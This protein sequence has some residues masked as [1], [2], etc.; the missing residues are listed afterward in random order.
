MLARMFAWVG[1]SLVW[2]LGLVRFLVVVELA[3]TVL[4]VVVVAYPLAA[5]DR[6]PPLV[7]QE[8][9][10]PGMAAA[11]R[12]ADYEGSSH[13][14]HVGNGICDSRLGGTVRA[15]VLCLTALRHRG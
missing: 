10:E 6:F 12:Q 1:R 4:V 8:G 14:P 3:S 15:V 7:Q 11:G 5:W 2:L 13:G 9:G